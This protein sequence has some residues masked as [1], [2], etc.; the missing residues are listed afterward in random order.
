MITFML[1]KQG[2]KHWQLVRDGVK[3][4]CVNQDKAKELLK[5]FTQKAI[6]A[7]SSNRRSMTR[8]AYLSSRTGQV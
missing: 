1:D 3:F 4:S 5:L 8:L 6:R 2:R 7:T